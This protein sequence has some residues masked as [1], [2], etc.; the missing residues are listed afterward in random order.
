MVLNLTRFEQN[1][2]KLVTREVKEVSNYEYYGMWKI[3]RN[4]IHLNELSMFVI[5]YSRGDDFAVTIGVISGIAGIA[6]IIG[7]V[8][9]IITCYY[10]IY[11]PGEYVLETLV[12]I[13]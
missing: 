11:K 13:W 6:T 5:F 3:T 7:L 12:L 8:I 4:G 2:E 1:F 9:T 10:Q